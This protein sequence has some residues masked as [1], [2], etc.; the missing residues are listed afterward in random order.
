[1]HFAIVEDLDADRQRLTELIRTN[2][3]ANGEEAEFSFF[4]SGEAFLRDLR[5]GSYS[6][7]FLDIMLAPG[8]MT[9]IAAAMQLR[10]VD[11][12][13]P[14]V[15]TTSETEFALDGYAA[16]PLDYLIK[17]VRAEKVAWCLKELRE[18]LEPAAFVELLESAGQGVA[19]SPRPVPLDDLLYAETVRHGIVVHTASGDIAARQTL[20]ELA[21]LL[22]K[23]GRFYLCGRSLLVNFSHV[24]DIAAD[25]EILLKSGE[26]FFCSRRRTRET[27]AA[28]SDYIFS[29]LRKGDAF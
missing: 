15:F 10:R 21:Q 2:C 28:F 5:R 29:R 1:M 6:A 25:G 20:S 4:P 8:G 18:R 17:P 13:V 26:T 11:E 12:R 19:P 22:P 3:A 24:Q 27:K 9:G 16:H 23:S 14:I 7:V